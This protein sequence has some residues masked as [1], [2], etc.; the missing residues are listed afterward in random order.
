MSVSRTCWTRWRGGRPRASPSACSPARTC[1]PR[2]SPTRD[3][4]CRLTEDAT[5]LG[6]HRLVFATGTWFAEQDREALLPGGGADL[7]RRRAGR[8]PPRAAAAQPVRLLDLPR[9]LSEVPRATCA[10]WRSCSGPTSTGRRRSAS[11]RSTAARPRHTLVDLNVSSSLRGDFTAAHTAGDNAHVLTTDAQKNT[12]FAFARDGVGAA[13]GVR[14]AAGPALRR[15][16]RLDHRRAGRRW[17]P[18]AGT[19]SP[20]AGS[21]T[22]TRSPGT[23]ARCGR[24]W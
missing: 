14:P 9:E 6:T 4:R 19:G 2:A 12:V 21:R 16:L 10:P 5:G 1:S 11:S 24:R 17:S 20:S 8:A 23:A 15:L 3:G 18:T 13:G 7:R 22:T